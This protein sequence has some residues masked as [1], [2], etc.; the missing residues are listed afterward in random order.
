MAWSDA[1]LKAIT[2]RQANLLVAA[3]AGSGKTSVLVERIVRRLL[4]ESEDFG[5]DRLLVVTFTN[6]AAAE[7]RERI[8]GALEKARAE[9]PA[10]RY[11]ERQ[12]LLANAAS[13]STLHAFCQSVVRQHFHRLDL[14]PRFRLANEQEAR[15]LQRDTL[16]SLFEELYAEEDAAF[17]RFADQYADARGDEALYELLLKLYEFARSQPNPTAWLRDLPAPFAAEAQARFDDTVWAAILK[18]DA[19]RALEACLRRTRA[20]LAETEADSFDFYT[21]VFEADLALYEALLASL[22]DWD[23]LHAALRAVKFATLRAPKGTDESRKAYYSAARSACKD[24]VKAL[25]EDVCTAAGTELQDDLAAARPAAEAAAALVERFSAA[26]ADA[27]RGRG[28]VDFGDLEHFC[29]DILT[30]ELLPDG[31]RRPSSVALALQAK[32]AEVMVDEYQD[33]NGVQEAILSLVRR[34]DAPNLFLVGDVKQSV[35]RFR[36]AE[37]ELFLDKYRRYG[38][39]EADCLRV[40][41]AQNF[42]S[43]PEI[44]AAVNF[45]FAQLLSPAVAELS[46][47]EAERLYPGPPYPP[48]PRSLAGP[49]ELCLIDRAQAPAETEVQEEAERS[50]FA[51]EAAYIA[52]RLR[53][54]MDEAPQVFDKAHGDYRPLAWRDIVVLL[55]S[56]KNKAGILLEALRDRDIPAY[57]AAD[58]GYFEA[59]EIRDMLSLLAV[60]DNPRQDIAL[61]AALHAPFASFTAEELAALRAAR[62]DGELCDAL[63]SA[64]SETAPSDPLRDKAARFLAQ[65]AR[66][67]TFS[68]YHSVPELLRRLFDETGYYDYAGGLPGGLLRQANLRMLYDRARQYETTNYRG[69]FRFLRFVDKLRGSGTDLPSARTLGESEDVVRVMSI[70]KSKGLEFPVVVVADLGKRFN[71]QDSAAPLLLHKKLGLGP[72]VTLDEPPQRYPT[73]AR[74]AIASRLRRESKAEELRVLYVALTRARERLIL[75][76]ALDNLAARAEAWSHCARP[77]ET[78]L[79]DDAIADARTYLDWIGPAAMRHADGAPLRQR[80]PEAGCAPLA[81]SAGSRWQISILPAGE[82]ARPPERDA[83]ESDLLARVRDGLSL[84]ESP[85]RDRVRRALDWTYPRQAACAIPTKL[86]VTELKRRF[87]PEDETAAALLRPAFK[88]AG[89]RFLQKLEKPTGAQFGTILHTALQHLSLDGDLS[90]GGVAAQL[91][92][93]AAREILLPEQA[94]AVDPKLISAYFASELGQRMLRSPKIRRETPFSLLLAAQ[95]FYPE[96]PADARIFVQGVVDVLFDEPGGMV[97]IDY[98]TDGG[99]P[100]AAVQKYRLQLALYAEAMEKLLQKRVKASYLYLLLSG[101]AIPLA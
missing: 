53:Q 93:L 34:A 95:R 96:A 91:E 15:L 59:T 71:L 80:A 90:P 77:G 17:L 46:Y 12:L 58:G 54:L 40:D 76:G 47:G 39:G 5:I 28:V 66:W 38:H 22:S 30:E 73:A 36:L 19:A 81:E 8:V 35:Y 98:K 10:S 21:P 43:R 2:A 70:H 55:R 64:A 82:L 44:L 87:S 75:V 42:R 25:R 63:L 99:S 32:Y 86:S 6:A 97:L 41:L 26:Y 45:L 16:D 37:P 9:R 33:T 1:Q 101:T 100:E 60:L 78:L 57:A 31:T 4:E 49:V 72:Y 85:A 52:Q 24:K 61:A 27:K 3:A 29:L 89:P 7:M 18:E 68:R 83:Q 67:R 23:A 94:R 48:S 20:L 84:P 65:C 13:V 14:D 11:L 56:P 50:A 69:L 79:S 51:P 74:R 92:A 62:P 88:A